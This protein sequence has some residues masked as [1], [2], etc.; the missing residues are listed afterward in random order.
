MGRPIN[1]LNVTEAERE[2]IRELYRQGLR[3]TEICRRTGRCDSVVSRAVRGLKRP[4]P[5]RRRRV[6]ERNALIARRVLDEGATRGR[7]GEAVPAD[8]N[9][10]LSDREGGEEGA[11]VEGNP[12]SWPRV[13]ALRQARPKPAGPATPHPAADPGPEPAHPLARARAGGSGSNRR[14]AVRAPARH[15]PA[16]RGRPSTLPLAVGAPLAVGLDLLALGTPRSLPCQ[17]RH[18]THGTGLGGAERAERDDYH[19]GDPPV[20][21][22]R[23]HTSHTPASS[24]LL[25]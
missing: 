9:L 13:R 25:L 11:G 6:T 16:D 12:E 22:A 4:K 17:R 2:R 20:V 21:V 5:A 3:L 14:A 1:S 18:L 10:D 19:D 7:D 23:Q 24:D 8:L 15:R